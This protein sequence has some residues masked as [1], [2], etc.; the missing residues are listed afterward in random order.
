MNAPL[1]EIE[2]TWEEIAQRAPEFKGHRMRL[3]VLPQE[4]GVSVAPEDDR[5]IEEQI[6]EIVADVPESEW[7]NLQ[8][9][10]SDHLDHYVYGTP[11]R[12]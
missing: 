2:G 6:A 3:A 11:K 9:D 1:L 8:S 7:A 12:T 10:L 4:S 5:P